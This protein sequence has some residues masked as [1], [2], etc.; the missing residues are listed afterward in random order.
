VIGLCRGGRPDKVGLEVNVFAS[1]RLERQREEEL[2]RF[3]AAVAA[4]RR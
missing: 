2:E 3:N 1:I 4:G